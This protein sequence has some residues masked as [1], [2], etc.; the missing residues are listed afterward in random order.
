MMCRY[1]LTRF[2]TWLNEL[3]PPGLEKKLAPTDC[4]L[5]PDQHCLEQG[6]YDQV[7]TGP[8][9]L[10]PALLHSALQM[11][12]PYIVLTCAC[13]LPGLIVPYT[14]LLLCC[15]FSCVIRILPICDEENTLSLEVCTHL[16]HLGCMALLVSG[17][18]NYAAFVLQAQK[19][20]CKVCYSDCVRALKERAHRNAGPTEHS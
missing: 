19:H 16:T 2:A 11:S 7:F 14:S 1:N 20:I 5:R 9:H 4:R 18:I 10:F 6:V 12:L 3:T 13:L 8:L 15:A 17:Q